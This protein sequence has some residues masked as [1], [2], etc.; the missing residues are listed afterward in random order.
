M[1]KG[2]VRLSASCIVNLTHAVEPAAGT[3]CYV[4]QCVAHKLW[5]RG[6]YLA[7]L[8]THLDQ[9]AGVVAQ[10]LSTSCHGSDSDSI[11]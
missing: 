9:H 4:C 1:T 8:A 10:G 3:G 7:L 5:P 2:A 11:A 6:V